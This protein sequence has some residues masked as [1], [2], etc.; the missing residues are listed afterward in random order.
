[1]KLKYPGLIGKNKLNE[2]K[3]GK[4]REYGNLIA[5]YSSKINDKILEHKD[6]SRIKLA[7]K[8]DDAR[9]IIKYTLQFLEN[10]METLLENKPKS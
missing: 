2:S 7:I 9:T 8:P 10:I 1:M 5:H 6:P 4:I 3:L